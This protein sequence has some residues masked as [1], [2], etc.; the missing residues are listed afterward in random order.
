[1]KQATPATSFFEQVRAV[2][3]DIPHGRVTTYGYVAAMCGS[4]RSA[5]QVGWALFV[6]GD[7]SIPWQRVVAANGYITIKHPHFSAD[8]QKNLLLQEG[9]SVRYDSKRK[10]YQVSPF[11]KY[12]WLDESYLS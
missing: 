8:V 9:V 11:S 7:M 2:V 1:M 4:P 6:S 10:L 5:R 12:V 3:R